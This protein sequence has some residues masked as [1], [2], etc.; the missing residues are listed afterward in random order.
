MVGKEKSVMLG[1]QLRDGYTLGRKNM[2]GQGEN[3][4]PGD[5]NVT[6]KVVK[7]NCH[8]KLERPMLQTTVA[9]KFGVLNNHQLHLH[10]VFF[11]LPQLWKSLLTF[12]ESFLPR[13]T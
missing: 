9:Q 4:I 2:D 10:I 1:E 3:E 8:L 6:A 11:S 12:G 7:R 5:W 13:N